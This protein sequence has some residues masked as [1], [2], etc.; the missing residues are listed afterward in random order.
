MS[1]IRTSSKKRDAYIVTG[2]TSGIGY[3]TA[4]ELAAS[5]TVILVGRNKQKLAAVQ[6]TIEQ[7]GQEAVSI[8]CDLSEPGSVKRAAQEIIALNLPIAGLLNNAGIM[9]TQ[10]KASQN[11]LGW[12]LTFATNYL[13]PFALT[14]VLAPHLLVGA[15][16]LF[17]TSA[18]EDS[19]RRPA[20]IVGMRGGRYLS[21]EASVRGEWLPGGASMPGVDA[22]ATS[23]QCVLAAALALART[24]P[25]LRFNAVE[26]GITPATSLGG[27]NLLLGLLFRYVI[28]FLPPFA[29]YR[30]TPE[31]TAHVI[32]TTFTQRRDE[33]GVYYDEKGRPM[34]GSKTALDRDFQERVIAQTRAFLA[35]VP[36]LSAD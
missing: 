14:E 2:P 1:V 4:L 32:S 5:G 6:K 27:P 9:E 31:R 25:H 30:S 33:T 13:G 7:R 26:P 23:K 15:R 12:D 34:V 16:V 3:Q 19:E 20:K 21:V 29:Q 8:V 11:S 28:T 24:T 17:V 35:T 22:Y 10:K 18:I 36:E